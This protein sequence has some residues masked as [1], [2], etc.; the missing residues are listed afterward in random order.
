MRRRHP[1]V[2]SVIAGCLVWSAGF[3]PAFGNGLIPTERIA[4]P[5]PMTDQQAHEPGDLA[6]SRRISIEASLVDAGVDPLHARTRVA[7]LTDAE[8]RELTQ[9][10]ATAPAGGVWFLPFLLVAAVIGVLIG[11]RE[12]QAGT[13][14]PT[15]N[16]FGHPRTIANA[17]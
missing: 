10:I 12:S 9:R 6:Q 11:T 4:A 2:V 7:A 5:M 8:I 14:P 13:R 15:T 17:P 3:N 16:L 1:L